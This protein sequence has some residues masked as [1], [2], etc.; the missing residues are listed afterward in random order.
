MTKEDVA[1]GVLDNELW[2]WPLFW[3]ADYAL[4]EPTVVFDEF[5]ELLLPE[6][7]FE[8]ILDCWFSTGA[9]NELAEGLNSLLKTGVEAYDWVCFVWVSEFCWEF[10][11]D[12][13]WIWDWDWD[14]DWVWVWDLVWV[15][16]CDC[17]DCDWVWGTVCD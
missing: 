1:G 11:T 3:L 13:D 10:D 9:G 8:L 16:G 6:L 5:A 14:W 15:C 4:E 12:C 2:V 7:L 17:L